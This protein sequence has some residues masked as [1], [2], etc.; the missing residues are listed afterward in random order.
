MRKLLA[1]FALGLAVPFFASAQDDAASQAAQQAMQANQQAMAD[2]QTANQRAID[3]MNEQM[4]ESQQTAQDSLNNT[5]VYVIPPAA[6][7]TFSVKSGTFRAPITVKLKTATRGAAIYY[8]TNGWT[9]TTSSKRY[10]GPIT[11]NFTTALQAIAVAPNL[12]RSYVAAAE[13]KLPGVAPQAPRKV[14]AVAQDP[15]GNFL[16]AK[17]TPIHLVFASDVTSKN[18]DVG[19]KLPLTLADDISF[20][21]TILVP[22]GTPVEAIVTDADGS[23]VAGTPGTITFEVHSFKANGITVFLRGEAT[24]EGQAKPLNAATLLPATLIPVVG[25]VMFFRHGDQAQI[26]QGTTFTAHVYADVL[27]PPPDNAQ[28]KAQ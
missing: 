11:I 15:C 21:Q 4:R 19:D 17:D 7:P 1:V 3:Q 12:A 23:R 10:E 8:T 28:A 13:Y 26:K 6:K 14:T 2:M 25:S 18:A 9:P 22:K 24:K 5:Q 16:L 27:F 20:G